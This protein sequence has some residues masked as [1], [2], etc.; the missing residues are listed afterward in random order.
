MSDNTIDFGFGEEGDADVNAATMAV[1]LSERDKF[2]RTEGLA[3]E[4][5]QMSC[6]MLTRRRELLSDE[7]AAG[8]PDLLKR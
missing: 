4:V 2:E 7:S 8:G 6:K 1:R 5:A 3:C